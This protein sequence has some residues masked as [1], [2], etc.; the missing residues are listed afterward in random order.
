MTTEQKYQKV[1][2]WTKNYNDG[3]FWIGFISGMGAMIFTLSLMEF[4]GIANVI[5]G[6]VLQ[7]ILFMFFTQYKRE[8][9][10]KKIK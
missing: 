9:Y 7:L 1:V 10:W 5:M 8:V 4:T 3:L 6:L 2:K